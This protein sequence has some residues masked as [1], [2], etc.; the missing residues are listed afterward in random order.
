VN[1]DALFRETTVHGEKMGR[2]PLGVSTGCKLT[3]GLFGVKQTMRDSVRA[4]GTRNN[5][6]ITKKKMEKAKNN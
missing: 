5:H 6:R 4:K 2:G 1:K 3:G